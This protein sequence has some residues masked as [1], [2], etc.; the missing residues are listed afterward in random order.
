MTLL[1]NRVIPQPKLADCVIVVDQE[2][3]L[4]FDFSQ[5][6][7]F[8]QTLVWPEFQ[9]G[10]YPVDEEDYLEDDLSESDSDF[11]N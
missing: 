7:L 6:R 8:D 9:E 1:S 4:L 10:E 11:S 2:N 3:D 5:E